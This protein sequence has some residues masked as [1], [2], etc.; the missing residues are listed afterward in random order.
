MAVATAPPMVWSMNQLK[1]G[2]VY[3]WGAFLLLTKKHTLFMH[4]NMSGKTAYSIKG[5]AVC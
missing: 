4:T 5:S 2:R 1:A 3:P